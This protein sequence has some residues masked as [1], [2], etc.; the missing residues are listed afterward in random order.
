VCTQPVT[1]YSTLRGDRAALALLQA[2]VLR[3]G[4]ASTFP[5]E[6]GALLRSDKALDTPDLQSHFLP[7]LSTAALR[8][9]FFRGAT[10]RHDGH[11]FFANV[12]RLRPESRGAITI[13]SADPFAAPVIRAN[14]LSTESDRRVLRE[15]IRRL[16][17]VFAQPAFDGFR[18]AELAPGPAIQSDA[19]LDAWLATTADTAFHPVGTAR[20]GADARAVVDGALRV[21]GVAGLRVADASVIPRMTSGNT[22]APTVM[23]AEKAA[24]L[25]RANPS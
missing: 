5:L 11:G 12:Y 7:G 23:I 25:M 1:L 13:R 8:L 6:A 21:R 18:G 3:S 19:D 16:R 4:P 20:M 15:G 9:P 24:D 2:L 14:Y 17:E 22:H 10:T